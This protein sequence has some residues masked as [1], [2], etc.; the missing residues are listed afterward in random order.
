[1]LLAWHVRTRAARTF[2]VH[3]EPKSTQRFG[4]LLRGTAVEM[5]KLHESFE[6]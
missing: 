1:E 3:G 6:L 5:P 4:A 2:L